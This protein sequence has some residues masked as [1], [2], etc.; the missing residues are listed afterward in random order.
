MK[1]KEQQSTHRL[2]HTY[3]IEKHFRETGAISCS[4]DLSKYITTIP[5]LADELHIS[6]PTLR[7]H[8]TKYSGKIINNK[9][10]NI[11]KVAKTDLIIPTWNMGQVPAV[12][13]SGDVPAV[14][15]SGDVPR[16][17]F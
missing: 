17:S 13:C 10:I 5:Q 6:D 11:V 2:L 9:Q 16:W 1:Q 15:C 7:K 3:I 8:L 4:G 12:M 14:M